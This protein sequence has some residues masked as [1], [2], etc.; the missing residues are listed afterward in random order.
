MKITLFWTVRPCGLVDLP[1]KDFNNI[2]MKLDIVLT[3][4]SVWFPSNQYAL[5]LDKT[6]TIKI[7]PT[8]ATSY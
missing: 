6:E 4:M 1:A 5:N 7:I 2:K 3:H 8:S